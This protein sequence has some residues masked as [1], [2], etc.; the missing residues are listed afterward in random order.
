MIIDKYKQTSKEEEEQATTGVQTGDSA[1]ENPFTP[2][3]DSVTIEEVELNPLQETYLALRRVLESLEDP[4]R[5][6]VQLFR[7]VKMDNGQFE[8]IV[9]SKGNT[10]YAIGFPAAF[11]R[12]VNVRYLVSQQRIGEGRATARIRYILNDLN[13]S[14][15]TMETRCFRVFE[16]INTAI[17]DAKSV[18]PALNERCNLTYWDMPESLDNGLQPFWIDYEIWF[19]SMSAYQYRNWVERYLVIPPFTN[20]SDAPSHDEE[21]HGDHKEPTIEEVAGFSYTGTSGSDESDE[22]EDSAETDDTDDSSETSESEETS[23]S[24]EVD[25][26][27]DSAETTESTETIES[28]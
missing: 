24:G 20:H 13:N 9:R 15:D 14:D 10:E 22:D 11:I 25:N 4:D 26:S 28:E 6:G 7:T 16:A 27:S 2:D 18:E 21:G 12:F 19:R 17:Q 5:E 1:G 3:D 8:R 23:D